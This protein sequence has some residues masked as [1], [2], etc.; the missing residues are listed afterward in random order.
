MN[1]TMIIKT[2]VT[3]IPAPYLTNPSEVFILVPMA[4][5]TKLAIF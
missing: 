4:S 3:F 5:V 2:S 1:K